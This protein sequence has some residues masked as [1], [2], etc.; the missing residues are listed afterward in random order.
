MPTETTLETESVSSAV[1]SGT[2]LS[3][4]SNG[5]VFSVV[6]TT[7]Y[8]KMYPIAEHEMEALDDSDENTA[9][10]DAIKSGS[11]MLGVGCV[12]SVVQTWSHAPSAISFSLTSPS[13]W[14]YPGSIGES[15]FIV[16]CFVISWHAYKEA[17]RYRKQKKT[18]SDKIKAQSKEQEQLPAGS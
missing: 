17:E 11:F 5:T 3:T 6:N 8:V 12:W 1:I 18:R 2:N 4:P 16:I 7:R 9:K 15:A 13:T 14:S 10:W